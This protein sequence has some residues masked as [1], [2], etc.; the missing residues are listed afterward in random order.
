MR[1]T[2]AASSVS[3]EGIFDMVLEDSNFFPF[4]HVK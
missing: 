2:T 1:V 4:E 3:P